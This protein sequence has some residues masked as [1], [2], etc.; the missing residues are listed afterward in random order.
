MSEA[1]ARSQ[2][3]FSQKEDP[4]DI[5]PLLVPIADIKTF[6]GVTDTALDAPLTMAAAM[7]SA[8]IRTYVGRML[9]KAEYTETFEYVAE[10]KIERY[11]IEVPIH[12]ILDPALGVVMNSQTGRVVLMAGPVAVVVYEG[13]Y[14]TLPADLMGV[15]FE[16][17][18][19]QMAFMGYDKIGT[20]QAVVAPPEKAIWVGTL[21]VEYAVGANSSQAKATGGGGFSADAMAPYAWILDSYRSHRRLVAT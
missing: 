8:A 7:V 10:P 12:T 11:L 21:K 9:T 14:E 5:D 18:R 16:L 20:S 2:V 3:R 13:G 1:A 4:S 15:F 6:F 17:V 19:Q